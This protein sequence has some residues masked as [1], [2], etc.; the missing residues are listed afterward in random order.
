MYVVVNAHPHP[1]LKS[2]TRKYRNVT[3]TFAKRLL[4]RLLNALFKK[5]QTTT[6][7]D[8]VNILENIKTHE[9]HKQIPRN[10]Q[11]NK[12]TLSTFYTLTGWVRASNV[13]INKD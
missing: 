9:Q 13:Q 3:G 6:T 10:V 12:D 2:G 8:L 5:Q 7:K 1:F 11:L 4:Q